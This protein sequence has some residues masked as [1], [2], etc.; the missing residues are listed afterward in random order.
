MYLPFLTSQSAAS[1]ASSLACEGK[2]P[3]H[4]PATFHT[5]T[6]TVRYL[7]NTQCAS[8]IHSVIL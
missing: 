8:F 2:D 1:G 7:Q 6:L 3:G 4:W 5:G